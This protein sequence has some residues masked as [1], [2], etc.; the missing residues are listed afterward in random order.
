MFQTALNNHVSDKLK[1]II[2]EIISVRES[3]GRS[4]GL[5]FFFIKIVEFIKHRIFFVGIFQHFV[6]RTFLFLKAVSNFY[7]VEMYDVGLLVSIQHKNVDFLKF[8][9]II[10]TVELC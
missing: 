9:S 4:Y 2:L 3:V 7:V 1:N 5:T 8:V 6:I 10:V